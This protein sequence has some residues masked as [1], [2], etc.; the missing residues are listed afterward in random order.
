MWAKNNNREIMYRKIVICVMLAVASLAA[1]AQ[2][3][4]SLGSYSPYTMYGLGDLSVGGT[5]SSRA[6]GGVGI[7]LRDSYEFNY[8][9]PAALSAI[10][11]RSALF[12]FAVSNSNYYQDMGDQTNAYNGSNLHDLSFAIPLAKGLGLGVSLTPLS[13]VGYST[14]LINNNEDIIS[15]IG[16][17]VYS[18]FGDGG[19]TQFNTSIGGKVVGG[20]S[21]GA[22]MHYEFGSINRT[23]DSQMYSLLSYETYRKVRTKEQLQ[24]D[25]LRFTFGGQYQIRVGSDDEIIIG[26][27]YTTKKHTSLDNIF[28]SYSDSGV[29]YDTVAFSRGYVDVDVPEKYAAGIS[30]S[31]PK[32]TVSFDY[33]YQ[34]W[35]DAFEVVGD[36]GLG[37]IDDY[38][39]G[40]SYTPD[41]NSLRSFFARMTYNFGVRYATS[42][43]LYKGE[44][45]QTWS[46]SMGFDMPIKSRNFSSFNFGL[47]FAT[48]AAET[49][50]LRE[51]YLSVFLGLT[52]FGGDD[53][54]F[55][56][57]K[58]N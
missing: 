1:N 6:K 54:W 29:L 49:V 19:V 8:L 5:V 44:Q 21:L 34:D 56:Q 46:V 35:S 4:S 15:D 25:Q 32:L 2:V 31:N 58:F 38:R 42:Y 18:Y 26:A 36:I 51:N 17:T 13:S 10:P 9:N 14:T 11:Q 48:R 3:E 41:R 28:L 33:S 12:S 24:V 16:R 47:E 55:M 22:T 45:P 27:T 7:A 23:W 50:I 57:R 52:L 37:A 39:F 53:M 43:L 30:F 20:L 40:V